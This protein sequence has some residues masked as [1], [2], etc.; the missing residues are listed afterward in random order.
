M[1]RR[2][3]RTK[4]LSSSLLDAT[5]KGELYAVMEEAQAIAAEFIQS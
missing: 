1:Y 4:Y 3:C 5:S 2:F